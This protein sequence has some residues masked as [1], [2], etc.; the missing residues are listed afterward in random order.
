MR[1]K[2]VIDRKCA[3]FNSPY[4]EMS[5]LDRASTFRMNNC[6]ATKTVLANA[7]L[8]PLLFPNLVS[9]PCSVSGLYVENCEALRALD[10]RYMF[11]TMYGPV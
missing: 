5:S 4:N 8:T 3:I 10:L 7:D 1:Y 11:D 9:S 2:R 6:D